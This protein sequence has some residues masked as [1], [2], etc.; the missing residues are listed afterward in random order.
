MT[1]RPGIVFAGSTVLLVAAL[2][3]FGPGA[4]DEIARAREPIG[5]GLAVTYA[6]GYAELGNDASRWTYRR[7]HERRMADGATFRII[8]IEGG[9][10]RVR[11]D[12]T[13]LRVRHDGQDLV[14]ERGGTIVF[15]ERVFTEAEA[16]EFFID[17]VFSLGG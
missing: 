14:A 11:C 13:A 5:C 12:G 9:E 6:N 2:T 4:L 1:A 16:R 3:Q 15:R 8:D 10:A 17:A 7:R